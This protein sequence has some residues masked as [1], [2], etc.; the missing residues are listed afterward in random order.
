MLN[1]WVI[2][3]WIVTSLG[4][5]PI[6]IGLRFGT[7]FECLEA[8]SNVAEAVPKEVIYGMD[9]KLAVEKFHV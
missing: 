5:T 9:C 4:V 1:S 7:L 2:I 3:S 6:E 8:V